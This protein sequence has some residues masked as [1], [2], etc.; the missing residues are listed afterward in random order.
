MENN[1]KNNYDIVGF[2]SFIPF[3]IF[4]IGGVIESSSSNTILFILFGTA[5]I[6]SYIVS[7]ILTIIGFKNEITW[8][9][10]WVLMF[11]IFIPFSNVAF[12][13]FKIKL[14]K[15]MK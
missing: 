6:I 7:V 5:I 9:Y 2:F 8:M 10:L 12:W 15:K 4:G 3:L 11:L 1:E 13:L 14:N